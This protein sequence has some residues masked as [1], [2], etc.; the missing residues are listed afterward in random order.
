MSEVE[1][2]LIEVEF[3]EIKDRIAIEFSFRETII[4]KDTLEGKWISNYLF[5]I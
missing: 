5:I 4:E 3:D 1:V 2:H